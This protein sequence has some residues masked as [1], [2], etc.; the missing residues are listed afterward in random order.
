M[1]KRVVLA[2]VNAADR[3]L[4]RDVGLVAAALPERL[5]SKVRT[6]GQ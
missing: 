5:R 4:L 1:P 6:L 3:A 2:D